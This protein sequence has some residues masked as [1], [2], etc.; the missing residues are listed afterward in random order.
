M[1]DKQD[2]G[3]IPTMAHLET[4]EAAPNTKDENIYLEDDPHRAALEDNPDRPE[5][6]TW[7]VCLSILFLSLAFVPSLTSGFI[8]PAGILIQIG[9]ELGDTANIAWLPGGWSIASSVSFSIAGSL[10]DIFGRR[11]VILIGQAMALV[12]LVRG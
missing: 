8:L 4:T 12:G 7:S 3:S 5:R 11:H 2:N 10:S 9:T 6:L 1:T